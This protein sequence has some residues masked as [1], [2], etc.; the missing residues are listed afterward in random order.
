MAITLTYQPD[1]SISFGDVLLSWGSGRT[2]IR[3]LL[4]DN[5][6]ISD[7][8]I[9]LS[10]YNNGDI[11]YNILQRRDIYRNFQG[12]DNFFS[13][14]FDNEDKLHE[15]EIHYGFDINIY[16]KIINF[17]MDIETVVE[18]LNNIS[19]DKKL[20]SDG[21]YLF[22]DLKLA[23]ASRDAMGG[24]GKEL[25]YFYCSKDVTHLTDS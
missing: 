20:L 17:S 19:G 11:S 18:L 1:K 3:K 14:N 25:A 21:E 6:E 10:Q 7:Q 8:V 23:V 5:F 13:I 4:N 9:D 15:I 12:H 24:D 2:Q 16:G 22:Q